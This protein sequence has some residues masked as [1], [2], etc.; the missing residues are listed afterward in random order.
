MRVLPPSVL[1]NSWRLLLAFEAP[2]TR[3]YM[4]KRQS[5]LITDEAVVRWT[6]WL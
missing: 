3:K 6:E 1:A 2:K 4:G 5:T